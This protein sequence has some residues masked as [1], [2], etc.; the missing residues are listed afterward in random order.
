[1]NKDELQ[2]NSAFRLMIDFINDLQVSD[3]QISLTMI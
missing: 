1:M 2:I 3:R